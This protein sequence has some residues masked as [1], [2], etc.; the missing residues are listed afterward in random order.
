M[1]VCCVEKMFAQNEYLLIV[2]SCAADSCANDD[3]IVNEYDRQIFSMLEN[4]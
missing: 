2:D 1:F 3:D 4:I